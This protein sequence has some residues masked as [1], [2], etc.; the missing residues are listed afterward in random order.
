M[1]VPAYRAIGYMAVGGNLIVKKEAL[2]KIGGFNTNIAFYGDDADLARR[3]SKIGKVVFDKKL[4]V[5]TSDRRLRQ[6]GV[7][8]TLT[9]YIANYI[10][11]AV[12]KK[13]ITKRYNDIR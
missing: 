1:A 10:S 8:K 6:E 13:P 11:V 4:A 2:E 5:H 7:T 12:L 3:L 9:N